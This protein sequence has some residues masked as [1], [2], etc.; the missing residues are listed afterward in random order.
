[1]SL[2]RFLRSPTAKNDRKEQQRIGAAGRQYLLLSEIERPNYAARRSNT[3][4]SQQSIQLNQAGCASFFAV[5]DG[6]TEGSFIRSNHS[7]FRR[8]I[9]AES[10]SVA[11]DRPSSSPQVSGSG[12]FLAHRGRTVAPGQAPSAGLAP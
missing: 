9:R 4:S 6:E 2:L 7:E 12:N 8:A 1:M 3:E 10:R 11:N 5:G